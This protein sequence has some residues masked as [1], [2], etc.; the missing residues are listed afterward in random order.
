V[1]HMPSHLTPLIQAS[2]MYCRSRG[3]D[4]DLKTR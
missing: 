3:P 4:S 2:E 1:I